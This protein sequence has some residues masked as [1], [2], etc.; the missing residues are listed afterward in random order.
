MGRGAHH[1]GGAVRS[2]VNSPP[3]H[4]APGVRRARLLLRHAG[5]VGPC[6]ASAPPSAP[7]TTP[8]SDP[9]RFSRLR[10][11]FAAAAGEAAA[12]AGG[13]ASCSKSLNSNSRLEC[14][15]AAVVGGGIGRGGDACGGSASA[16][17][18]RG[19]GA[20]DALPAALAA[21][22]VARAVASA[23]DI[24]CRAERAGGPASSA[25]P[26]AASSL[27][28]ATVARFSSG[29]TAASA[30][31]TNA[32]ADDGESGSRPARCQREQ[33]SALHAQCAAQ[34]AAA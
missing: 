14:F 21:V 8:G 34:C 6:S 11:P 3:S 7:S 17:G 30:A 26:P 4:Q 20:R 32:E 12:A 25:A 24:C 10:L 5:V 27:R 9:L 31:G 29:A 2:Q 33:M 13:D 1:K 16:A 23:A 22:A 18:P 15:S 19:A 28:A